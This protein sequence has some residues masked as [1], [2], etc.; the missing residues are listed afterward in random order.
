MTAVGGPR[1]RA[2]RRQP[3]ALRAA[4]RTFM[5][6]I[7]TQDSLS[8][9]TR[10]PSGD[11]G[12]TEAGGGWGVHPQLF[13]DND[14]QEVPTFFQGPR[15]KWWPVLRWC[16][17]PVDSSAGSSGQRGPAGR[18]ALGGE[19]HTGGRAVHVVLPETLSFLIL[20]NLN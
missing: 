2:G 10:A 1:R 19:K 9:P 18:P 12:G 5:V 13:L 20:V 8:S 4:S 17:R 3:A 14:G 16:L 7:V 6:S 15:N 11:T